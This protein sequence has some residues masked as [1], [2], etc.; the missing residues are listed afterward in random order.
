MAK[1]EAEAEAE[2]RSRREGKGLLF[3]LLAGVAF[4]GAQIVIGAG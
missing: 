1:G 2:A 4:E 3:A